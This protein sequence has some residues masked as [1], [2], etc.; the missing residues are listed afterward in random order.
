MIAARVGSRRGENAEAL[1]G[2]GAFRSAEQ[3][4]PSR[5]V[6]HEWGSFSAHALGV[7]D[8]EAT[9]WDSLGGVKSR[10]EAY[11]ESLGANALN[12]IE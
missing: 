2:S 11:F 9:A 3:G 4:D 7:D 1:G 8:R 6:L 10:G 12:P 5:R